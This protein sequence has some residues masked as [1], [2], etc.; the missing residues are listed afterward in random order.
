MTRQVQ[1]DIWTQQHPR[2]CSD[3]SLRFLVA[4]WERLPGFGIGAQLA[5]MSGLLAIAIK[6]KRV[7]VTNH[8]NR[9]DHNSCKGDSPASLLDS[10]FTLLIKCGATLPFVHTELWLYCIF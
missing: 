1:R 8:Y 3:P 7:L 5:G 4:D 10:C 6:E 2:N 9:A